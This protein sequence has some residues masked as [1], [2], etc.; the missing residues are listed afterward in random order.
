[1][2]RDAKSGVSPYLDFVLRR[3]EEAADGRPTAVLFL[4]LCRLACSDVRP[5]DVDRKFLKILLD[6]LGIDRAAVL[7]HLPRE[8]SHAVQDSL[9]FPKPAQAGIDPPDL[10]EPFYSVGDE[11]GSGP[12]ADGLRRAVGARHILWVFDAESGKSL[13]LGNSERKTRRGFL[14]DESSREIAGAALELYLRVSGQ[15][16]TSIQ[17]AAAAQ[18]LDLLFHQTSDI[19]LVLDADATIAYV[20]R[21]AER[22]LGHT[23]EDVVGRSAFDFV[24]PEDRLRFKAG[25]IR[26]TESAGVSEQM[27]FRVG[28]A[29]GSWRHFEG[30]T[31][32]LLED[33]AVAGMVV[34]ARDITGRKLLEEEREKLILSMGDRVKELCCMYE[35]AS[36][37][38]GLS[39]QE[40]IFQTVAGLIPPG[41]QYPEIARCR[42]VF[43]E[44]GYVSEP[45]EETEWRQSSDVIVDGVRRGSVEVFY[46]E[47]RPEIDEGPFRKEERDIIDGIARTIGE[48]VEHRQ[49]EKDRSELQKTIE[50]SKEAISITS[51]GG[52][53]IYTN[54]A[55][56]ELFGYERGELIGKSPLILSAASDPMEKAKEMGEVL[57]REGIW[58]GEYHNRRKDGT[59]FIGHVR[60]TVR[61][62]EDGKAVSYLTAQRDVTEQVR[63]NRQLQF[64]A[65]LL[66]IANRHTKM[67]SMLEDFVDQILEFTGCS[68]AGVRMLDADGNIPYEAQRGFSGKFYELENPLSVNADK[69]M[70]VNVINRAVDPEL[71]C[72]KDSGCFYTS[73]STRLLE[74]MS[75]ENRGCV[76]SICSSFGYESVALIPVFS[77]DKVHGLIHVADERTDALSPDS[78]EALHQAALLLGEA[79]DRILAQEAQD[80]AE[81]QLEEQ[82]ALSIASDRLRSLGEMAAG[83]AHE[84]NQPLVGVRGLAEHIMIGLDRGW[85][86]TDENI[87]EKVRLIV[88]QSERM[89]HIIDHIR[90]FAKEAGRPEVDPVLVNDVILSSAGLVNAQLRARGVELKFGLTEDL[91][92]VLANPFSLEEVILNLIGNARDAIEEKMNAYP[93]TTE[94]EILLRTREGS[95]PRDGKGRLVLIEVIDRGIGIP[96]E[97]LPRVFDPFFTTKSP[98]KGTGLGLAV[99]RSIIEELGGTLEI[100]SEPG[101]GTT[102]VIALEAARLDGK[103]PEVKRV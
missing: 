76:R 40:E 22:I 69:C 34:N 45:F 74:G 55:M 19:I 24:H 38:R 73:C 80:R 41:Y 13:L 94:S 14:L 21:S 20:S 49:A 28:H 86:F 30:V 65:R 48:A 57:Q 1:L 56:D 3:E 75:D 51:F 52:T 47:E 11:S 23:P 31:N 71:A 83:I 44:K 50:A 63:T 72:C 87:R 29:D 32:N 79:V 17:Q 89:T 102:A 2:N 26:E 82:R 98:D 62:D 4:N 7:K 96:P 9:G 39:S 15:R 27:E 6:S 85:K 103:T 59:E 35:V 60:V 88:E 8:A 81:R 70:C 36:S 46:L 43:D 33:P 5:E 90:V 68:A 101:L 95:G 78:V 12:L 10:M 77:R 58:E 61:K 25:F 99:S 93:A 53:I 64:S 92:C 18:R 54:P 42:V 97:N 16:I 66:E 100:R 37:I 84:L 67:K 91:P